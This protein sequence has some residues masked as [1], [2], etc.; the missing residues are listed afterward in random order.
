MS[1]S[2]PEA[3]DYLR[4]AH[5]AGRLG[6]A[7][8]FI[9]PSAGSTVGWR[10][11]CELIK[12]VNGL[13]ARADAAAVRASPDV[14]LAEPESKSRRIVIEQVRMLEAA[15]RLR[16]AAIND[17]E[18]VG[19]KEADDTRRPRKVAILRDADRLQ[20]QAAN[21]FLKTLEEPPDH[22]LLLLLTAQPEAMLDTILSRC[23]RVTLRADPAEAAGSSGRARPDEAT[24]LTALREHDAR[25]GQA[26]AAS[27][28]IAYR[29]LRTFQTLLSDARARLTD[30]A[31]AALEADEKRYAQ[32]TDSGKAYIEERQDAL[33]AQVEARF[34]AERA[35]LL[36]VLACWW[37]DTL[38][39]ARSA[40]ETDALLRK[41]ARLDELR[42]QLERPVQ[43]A[44]AL[45]VAFLEIFAD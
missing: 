43:E 38:R 13:P 26:S 17:N 24:L 2:L 44:L 12:T 9:D 35:R 19:D 34:V 45:E 10:L 18:N 15:L 20:P 8:L 21:A 40:G 25:G 5:A 39:Q 33:K 11:A 37:G 31:E 7:Y 36:D 22:S 6:H 4:R 28:S 42:Q 1:F 23:I 41:L 29:L 30:E 32:T 16:A 27:V 3:L 14:H